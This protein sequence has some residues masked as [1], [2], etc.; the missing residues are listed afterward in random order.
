MK[1]GV[2]EYKIE[3]AICRDVIKPNKLKCY[4]KIEKQMEKIIFPY[5]VNDRIATVMDEDFIK[6]VYPCA[7]AYLLEHK[8]L[9]LQ[10]DKNK[11]K[12]YKWFEFGRSQSI[13]DYGKKLLFPYMSNKAYFV[14]SDYENLMFY[15]GYAIYS[16]SERELK[17]IEKILK[18]KIFWYYIQHVSKP[19]SS[20]YFALA[21][22]YVKN[23]GIC[24]L[25]Q[26][27]ED[28]LLSCISETEVDNF[29]MSKYQVSL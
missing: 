26:S 1:Y 11:D 2:K 23:F 28:F 22:N 16:S 12:K 5:H 14:Y 24:N 19:Y 25:S 20:N 15:A 18:S 4:T 27:E 29:L 17:V 9:L 21:K 6:E 13:N 7:Y 10:R 8:H 3:K